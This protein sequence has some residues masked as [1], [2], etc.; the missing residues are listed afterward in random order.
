MAQTQQASPIC[1]DIIVVGA[2]L[3]GLA[4]SISCALSGHRV[5]IV[6]SAKELLEIGAG[7]QVTPNSSRLLQAWDLHGQLWESGAEPSCLTVH[8]Y[9][10]GKVLAHDADFDQKMRTRYG[11]P[12]V[13]FHRVDVQLALA[14]RA[15]ELGVTFRMGQKV[16]D[17]DFESATV[18]L[19]SGA[20][21]TGDLIIAA[22]GLWSR[23]RDCFFGRKDPP[24][25]TGDLAYR[26]VLDLDQIPEGELRERVA[27]PAVHFWIGPGGHAV[28]Y[29]LR[30]GS[31]YNIVLLVPDDLPEGVSKQPGSVE[32]MRALFADWDP[33]LRQYLDLVDSVDKW[34]LM[35]RDELPRWVNDKSNFVF[36]GDACHPMLPYLAQGANSAIED[37]AVLGLLLGYIQKKEHI[38]QALHMY[39]RLRKTRGEAIVRET[40]A[41][42]KAFH[43]QDGPEQVSR[44]ELFLSQLGSELQAPYPSRWSC[45]D[46]QK[47]LYGYNAFKEV[48]EAVQQD[49]F[50]EWSFSASL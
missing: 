49:P 42:R 39:E 2:G 19:S 6:E 44:D 23:C 43:M 45:P 30:G 9:S 46:V 48:Q 7:L 40:F 36:I 24:K 5:T 18:H 15:R 8:R 31:M 29:S 16:E 32:E 38:P 47:W 22:D 12:F 33:V 17:V 4:A 20:S 25:P 35:H 10:D 50:R 26:I 11:A 37:G 28:G 21:A 41:Q 1:L 34:K 3:S 13:D 14:A 27:S